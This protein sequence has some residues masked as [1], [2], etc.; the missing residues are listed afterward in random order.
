[1]HILAAES[2][3]RPKGGFLEVTYRECW[4]AHGLLNPTDAGVKPE[5]RAKGSSHDSSLLDDL[6]AC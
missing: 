3:S 4:L 2:C 5:L 1:M 6:S